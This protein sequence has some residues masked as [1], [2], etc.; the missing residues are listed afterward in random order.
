MQIRQVNLIIIVLSLGLSFSI[1]ACQQNISVPEKIL[2]GEGGWTSKVDPWIYMRD[3]TY[4]KITEV[5]RAGNLWQRQ[6]YLDK[7]MVDTIFYSPGILKLFAFTIERV[8]MR[9]E[10]IEKTGVFYK[11]R[12]N[13]YVGF[14]DKIGQTWQLYA[15]GLGLLDTYKTPER[16]K[17]ILQWLYFE[18]LKNATDFILNKDGEWYEERFGANLGERD[19]WT[20]MLW[21]K[22]TRAPGMYI[23]Q[24]NYWPRASKVPREQIRVKQFEPVDYPKDLLALFE[25][26]GKESKG[27]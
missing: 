1:G 21:Q 20:C 10:Y 25:K 7:V 11:Y 15:F 2:K 3:T 14:R 19:F 18:K 8:P 5:K 13:A 27:N 17:Q 22:G 16:A 12:Q 23:F 6:G 4:I 26:E 24:V 9:K